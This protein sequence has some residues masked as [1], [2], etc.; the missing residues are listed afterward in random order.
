MGVYSVICKLQA[1]VFNPEYTAVLK[2]STACVFQGSTGS[3]SEDI[4]LFQGILIVS[5]ELSTENYLFCLFPATRHYSFLF[6]SG[7]FKCP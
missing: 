3:Q 1:I 6:Q 4:Q 7:R 5:T 2:H